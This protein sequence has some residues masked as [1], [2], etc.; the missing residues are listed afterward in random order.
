MIT[1]LLL[2]IIYLAF[3]SLG[4]PDSLL[5]VAWPA[6]QEAWGLPVD[7]IGIVSM[8]LIGCTIISSFMSEKII[9]RLGTGMTT[10]ISCGLTGLAL[11]GIAF[12]PSFMWLILLVIP[13]GLGGGSVDAA[14]NNYVALHFK[15]HHMNWLHSFWG[16]GA[17]LGPMIMANR[18]LKTG[19][20]HSGAMTIGLIQL[21]LMTILFLAL[22]LWKKHQPVHQPHDLEDIQS[23]SE[24]GHQHI[25]NDN[26]H[27]TK[28]EVHK[29]NKGNQ[30][31]RKKLHQIKG[32]PY[33]LMT[34]A[35]YCAVEHGVGLW[36]STFL[37][38]SKLLSVETAA[39]WVGLYYG[40][41]TI[42]RFA[43]GFASFKLNNIQLMRLGMFMA[44]LGT[45]LLVFAPAGALLLM[46]FILLGIGLAPIF[47]SI[48]HETPNRFG[49][50]DTQRIIGVQMGFAYI[51]SAFLS[52]VWGSVLRF[53]ST[54]LL[55][56]LVAF[57]IGL[58]ILASEQ[59]I[60]KTRKESL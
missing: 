6:M 27:S 45:L 42:G 47:P 12:A 20:W 18:L 23:D 34:I 57:S 26:D 25:N 39:K 9:N 37:V 53:T 17:T 19:T 44:L 41:I 8:T 60:R 5:G 16:V 30:H 54:G 32:L 38:Q 49:R 58:L 2:A 15:A 51:G 11:V 48:L 7:A 28:K 36:G 3:I 22:P 14:L 13:L 4:L 50:Q 29:G 55:P 10:F 33:A 40:G 52:P 35:M 59:V 1:V 43:A 21:G 56:Y 46:G 24:M 31:E